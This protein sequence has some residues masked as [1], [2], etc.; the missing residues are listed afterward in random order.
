MKPGVC[1]KLTSILRGTHDGDLLHE[2]DLR[3]IEDAANGILND[4]GMGEID[5]MQQLVESGEYDAK[6]RWLE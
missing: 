3:L 1:D 2:L 5:T 6:K 4:I